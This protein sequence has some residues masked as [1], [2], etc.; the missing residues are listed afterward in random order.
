LAWAGERAEP[1]E[2]RERSGASGSPRASVQGGPGDEVP[3]LSD[4]IRRLP[5]RRARDARGGRGCAH[6]PP[7]LPRQRADLCVAAYAGSLWDGEARTGRTE[8][9]LEGGATYVRT[10]GWRLGPSGMHERDSRRGRRSYG[11]SRSPTCLRR[12]HGLAAQDRAREAGG[13]QSINAEAEAETKWRKGKVEANPS[14]RS[15]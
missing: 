2:P 5:T 1:S 8:R 9:A 10:I 3:R 6:G 13:A 11:Q 4:D 12:R 15:P 7:G 14:E